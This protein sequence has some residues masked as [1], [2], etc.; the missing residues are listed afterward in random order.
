[1]V[2]VVAERR[3]RRLQQ[4][5]VIIEVEATVERAAGTIAMTLHGDRQRLQRA[6]AKD[7]FGIETWHVEL[8]GPGVIAALGELQLQLH[9]GGCAEFE[10]ELRLP[11]VTAGIEAAG[12]IGIAD[13]PGERGLAVALIA[14]AD[15]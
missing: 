13:F 2:E 4:E 10:R 11:A 1:G 7:R 15:G 5:L 6:V 8:A 12:I 3:A 9:H 14:F